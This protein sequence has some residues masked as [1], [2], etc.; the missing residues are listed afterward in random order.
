MPLPVPGTDNSAIYFSIIDTSV[1]SFNFTIDPVR[2]II[3][4][5]QPIDFEHLAKIQNDRLGVNSR[6]IKL[7]IKAQ[8]L[9][10]PSL[11][12]KVLVNIYV[13]DVNDNSPQFEHGSYQCTVS[14]DLVGG[15]TVIQV[16]LKNR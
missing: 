1:K 14:E 8:D 5:M 12:S 6:S 13:E 15:S 3:K 2:G 11:S 4:P 16:S 9:G 7:Y 10:V